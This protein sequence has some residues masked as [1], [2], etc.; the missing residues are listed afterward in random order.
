M[1]RL[2][3]IGL[4]GVKP[5]EAF[6]VTHAAALWDILHSCWCLYSEEERH[7]GLRWY[8]KCLHRYADVEA[9][10]SLEKYQKIIDPE[11]LKMVDLDYEAFMSYQHPHVEKLKNEVVL[12]AELM[13]VWRPTGWSA[14]IAELFSR[15]GPEPQW[16]TP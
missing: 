7:E 6:E 9:Y 10:F 2:Y 12:A 15:D 11:L 16:M 4:R 14:Q 13:S 3:N 5:L 1:T 8:C